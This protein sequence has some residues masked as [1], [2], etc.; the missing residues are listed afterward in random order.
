MRRVE[1]PGLNGVLSISKLT[2]IE[3]ENA[4]YGIKCKQFFIFVQ[5]S[6]ER[7]K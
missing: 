2:L 1:R 7:R 3:S 4:R 5:N 6:C